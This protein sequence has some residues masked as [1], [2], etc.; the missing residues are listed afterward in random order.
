MTDYEKYKLLNKITKYICY[1][2]EVAI[3]VAGITLGVVVG[4]QRRTIK[5][6]EKQITQYEHN[7]RPVQQEQNKNH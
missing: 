1:F 2:L 7:Y 4:S 5:Q 3:V 6:Q